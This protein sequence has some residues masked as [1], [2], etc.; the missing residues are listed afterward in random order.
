MKRINKMSCC[1]RYRYTKE[2]N[3][4]SCK[5]YIKNHPWM[6]F[7]RELR[8]RCNNP[9]SKDYKNYGEKGIKALITKDEIQNLWFKDKAYEMKKP[10][11]YQKKS[12]GNYALDN[13]QFLE[14]AEHVNKTW[15][16]KNEI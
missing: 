12:K 16:E 5:K 13:C 1:D 11:I 10:S 14:M 3:A 4:L 2:S 9:N 7:L 8:T 15:R 6:C